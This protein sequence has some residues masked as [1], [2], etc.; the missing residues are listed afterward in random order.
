M[1]GLQEDDFSQLP[2]SVSHSEDRFHWLISLLKGGSRS[3]PLFDDLIAPPVRRWGELRKIHYALVIH[4]ALSLSPILTSAVNPK[5]Q[6]FVQ[7][8]PRLLFPSPE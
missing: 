6:P 4:K 8:G 3:G 1:I 5:Q 2:G 7:P